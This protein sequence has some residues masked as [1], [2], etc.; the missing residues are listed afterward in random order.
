MRYSGPLACDHGKPPATP[1]GG[2][3]GHLLTDAGPQLNAIQ[4]V[5][6]RPPHWRH[7]HPAPGGELNGK[8]GW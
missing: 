4:T 5:I 3:L 2:P 6:V 7:A 8:D 1:C